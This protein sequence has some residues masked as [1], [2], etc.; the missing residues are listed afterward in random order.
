MFSGVVRG[1]DYEVDSALCI[2]GGGGTTK[3]DSGE[4]SVV[5]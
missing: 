2:C 5:L 3:R 4:L 1:G